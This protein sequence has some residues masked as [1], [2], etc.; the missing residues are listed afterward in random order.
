M[1]RLAMG[2]SLSRDEGQLTYCA[3][4]AYERHFDGPMRKW[5]EDLPNVQKTRRVWRRVAVVLVGVSTRRFPGETPNPGKRR[6]SHPPISI[7]FL[8]LLNQLINSHYT[9]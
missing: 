2:V 8:L 7:H 9:N 1:L 4:F 5:R 6:I 3:T